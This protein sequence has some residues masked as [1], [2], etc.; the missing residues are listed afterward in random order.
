MEPVTVT[1]IVAILGISGGI[2]TIL[3]FF[4]NRDKNTTSAERR[5]TEIEVKQEI[6]KKELDNLKGSVDTVETRLM[7]KLDNLGLKF[8]ALSMKFIDIKREEK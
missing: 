3:S 2:I 4:M 5:I 8:D 6:Y 1:L 7:D